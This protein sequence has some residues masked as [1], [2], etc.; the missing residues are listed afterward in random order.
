MTTSLQRWQFT[1]VSSLGVGYVG[2][3]FCRSNLSV[4]AP[5]LLD[6]YGAEGFDKATLGTLV[7]FGVLAY[8]AGKL[9]M[10]TLTDFVGGRRVFLAGLLAS[11]AATVAFG[12]SSGVLLFTL[13]WCASRLAQAGGW[14]A[15]VKIASHWFGPA[16][17]GAVM[18]VLALTYP[19]GDFLAKLTLG[20]AIAQGTGWRTVFFLAAGAGGAAALVCALLLRESPA[21][22]GAP[23]LATSPR[24]VFGAGAEASKPES[25]RALFGPLLRSRA[26]L[27]VCAMS[28]GL[29][30][31]REAF[32]F[33]TPTFL[34]DAARLDPGAAAK[35][36]SIFPFAGG[37]SVL[38][39]GLVSDRWFG[40]KR[41]AVMVVLLIV[42]TLGIAAL[43]LRPTWESALVPA[44]L[45]SLV[46]AAMTGPYAMLS[47]AIAIDLG[48]RM[49]SSTVAGVADAVGYLGSAVAGVAVGRLA[50]DVGWNAAFALL[51][52]L[53]ATTVAAAAYYWHAHERGPVRGDGG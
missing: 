2:Y 4:A 40:G 13:A 47:G 27:A 14:G 24:S 5:L 51:A 18:G 41:G 43:A 39:A 35:V 12:F 28:F 17:L 34:V 3:Y 1:T 11:V 50:S 29:T 46:G 30:V 23:A 7:S 6:E 31:I 21:E 22:V 20:E 16:R 45:I 52:V 48:G 32:T 38:G 8:A 10:G 49:G 15:L 25:L 36:A 26:F 33:W 37:F 19:F 44:L 9:L 42:A 53:S